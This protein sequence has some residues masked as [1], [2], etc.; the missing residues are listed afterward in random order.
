MIEKHR[1][2]YWSSIIQILIDLANLM[3]QLFVYFL[4]KQEHNNKYEERLFFFVLLVIGLLS[5]LPSASP[6]V[7]IQT[8]G[9]ISIEFGE[10]T[11]YLFLWKNS[12][13]V[14]IVSIISFSIE[15]I[16]HLIHILLEHYSNE[17]K[18][19]IFV[20]GK[21]T[22]GRIKYVIIRSISYTIFNATSIFFLFLDDNSRFHYKFYEILILLTF[23]FPSIALGPALES[24]TKFKYEYEQG[25]IPKITNFLVWSLLCAT[26]YFIMYCIPLSITGVVFAI[27][28]LRET[29]PAYSYDFIVYVSSLTFFSIAILVF[30][31]FMLW[32]WRFTFQRFKTM[33]ID[34]E[35]RLSQSNEEDQMQ[36]C[37]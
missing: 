23:Y 31:P 14:I 9:S 27:Q 24:I 12:K 3:E 4:V 26:L 30:P 8:I 29:S 36:Y 37:L 18:N 16:L 15:F 22:C 13:S 25:Q 6:Y 2:E 17:N 1:H 19:D 28:Q 33:R 21:T 32:W 34:A 35:T 7:Y 20:F 10:L 5:N 11:A